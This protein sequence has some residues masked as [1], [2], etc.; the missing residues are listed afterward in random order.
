MRRF[1]TFAASGFVALSLGA[2]AH[3]PAATP[4]PP[5]AATAPSAASA[6]EDFAAAANHLHSPRLMAMVLLKEARDKHDANPALLAAL[7]ATEAQDYDLASQATQLAHSLAPKRPEAFAIDVRIALDQGKVS[8][9]RAAASEAYVLGGADAVRLALTGPIDPWF[10][11]AVVQPLAADHPRDADLAL[12][13]AQALLQAG[14]D[15]GAL[16]AAQTAGTSAGNAQLARTIEIQANWDL[17][18]HKQ[19]LALAHKT[20]AAAPHDVGLRVFVAG[21]LARGDQV[22]R[23]REI[24]DDAHALAPGNTHVALAYA[25]VDMAAGDT[26]AARVRVTRLLENGSEAPGLYNLLGAMAAQDG[27]WDEAFGWYHGI[28][29]PDFVSSAQ[30]GAVLALAQWQGLAPAM[31]YLDRLRQALPALAPTWIAVEATLLAQA[32][33]TDQAYALL[34]AETAHYPMV[35]PLRYQQALLADQIGKSETALRLLHGLVTE[36]PDNPDYLNAYGYTLTEHTTRYR[37]AYGY[38]VKALTMSPDNG[39]ILDSMGWV[40]Y[41]LGE[42]TKAV[43]YLRRAWELTGDPDV[44][45]HLVQVYLALGDTS[46]ASKL[47]GNALAKT[48]TDATLLKLKQQLARSTPP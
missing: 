15:S 29:D 42:N 18:R 22:T 48:P 35:Q 28:T 6:N 40:L 5:P 1:Y 37:E 27:D 11:L 46:A 17:G 8:D 41:R 26:S 30:V 34:V 31:D 47:L 32:G 36:A 12:F 16:A 4:S 9:A 23:A 3:P 14:D 24:L 45:D 38:I 13:H 2:C 21:L 39:A 25:V 10:V 7:F 19:A 20:L 33:K 43:P 44:A